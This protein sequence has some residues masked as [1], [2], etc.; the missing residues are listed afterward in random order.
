MILMPYDGG[1]AGIL[2]IGT[3]CS[4]FTGRDPRTATMAQFV[5]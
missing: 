5:V 2:V 3:L 1:V 4:R